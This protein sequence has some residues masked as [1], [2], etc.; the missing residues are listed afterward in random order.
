MHLVRT[1]QNGN[2][3][4][5]TDDLWQ[6]FTFFLPSSWNGNYRPIHWHKISIPF[7]RLLAPSRSFFFFFYVCL[8]V[9][10]FFYLPMRLQVWKKWIKAFTFDKEGSRN[11]QPKILD[12][13]KSP[14]FIPSL[15]GGRGGSVGTP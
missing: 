4:E 8:F 12:N 10:L 13:W 9:C 1:D 5:Q 6:Y 2:S 7:C 3:P 14:S 15:A 11:F